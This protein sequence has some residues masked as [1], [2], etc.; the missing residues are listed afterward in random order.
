MEK[1]VMQLLQVEQEVNAKVK[2]AQEK[3]N[4]L[5]MSVR[6]EAEISINHYKS[7]CEEH[8]NR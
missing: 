3:R 4:K 2:D 6:K 5:L 7:K 1:N 8:H